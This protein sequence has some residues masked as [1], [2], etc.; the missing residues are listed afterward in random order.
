M[1]NRVRQK[2]C[3]GVMAKDDFLN[4]VSRRVENSAMRFDSVPEALECWARTQADCVA[5]R[6]LAD[7]EGD[8]VSL[9]YAELWHRAQG[10]AGYLVANGYRDQRV[11]LLMPSCLEYVVAFVACLL[12][13]TVA[14]PLYPPR[15]NW[16]DKRLADISNDAQACAALTLTAFA[17]QLMER[18]RAAGA[19]SMDTLVTVDR[20]AFEGDGGALAV[21]LPP[22]H[23]FV[24]AYLQYTSGSTGSPKGVMVRQSDIAWNVQSKAID[25][26]AQEVAV[27][28]LPL[29]HDMGLVQGIVMPLVRGGTAVFMPPTAF[30]QDPLRWLRAVDR[31]K[32]VFSGAPN[33]GYQSC[34]DAVP[35]DT[36]LALDLSSWR[37]AL[38]AAEPISSETV[39]QFHR[40]F[41]PYGLSRDAL[42]G[43]FGMAEATLYVT[44]GSGPGGAPV[45]HLDRH[46][47]SM[48]QIR[49]R[50]PESESV[51]ALVSSG[52]VSTDPLVRIVDT[53]IG[54]ALEDCQ[55]GEIWVSGS[56]V[57][58]G[59]WHNEP[60]T[61]ESFGHVLAS[62]PGESFLRT[63]DLGFT[64]QGHLYVT[65]RLK[66]LIIV[67]GANHYPQDI[68][69]D[70]EKAHP[71]F[72]TGRFSAAFTLDDRGSTAL[73]VVQEVKRTQRRRVD[74]DEIGPMVA[75]LIASQHGIELDQ[76]VLVEPGGVP[77]TSSGKVQRKAC[78]ALLL[79]G[80]L[81][82]IAVWTRSRS[83]PTVRP[84]PAESIAASRVIEN[85]LIGEVAAFTGLPASHIDVAMSFHALGLDS[86]KLVQLSARVGSAFG[87]RLPPSVIFDHP[88]ITALANHLSGVAR[89]PESAADVSRADPVAIIGLA[90]RVPGARDV[91]EFWQLVSS[92]RTAVGAVSNA[93]RHLT[94]FAA[95]AGSP[96]AYLGELSG[97]DVFDARLFGLAAR[98]VSSMDPQQRLALEVAWHALEN[99]GVAAD[100]LAGSATG[101][102]V[103][104]S[105]NDYFRLQQ[106]TGHDEYAATG[107]ALSI[108]ANR[109]SY[110]LGLQGPS[111]AI[112][113]ACSSSLVAVHQACQALASDDC[114]L[115]IAGG[116]NLVLSADHGDILAQARMLSADGHCHTFDQSAN[117]YVRGEGCGFVVL[118][119][120]HAAQRDGDRVLAVIRGSA[121]NQDGR[122][123]GLTAPN[124]TAQRQLIRTALKRA[125]IG[126]GSIGLVETHGTGTPL[127]DP[128]EVAALREVL[129]DAPN[130]RPCFLGAVKTNIGHLESAAGI[131]GLIKATMALTHRVIPPN[132]GFSRLNPH[133]DL[134][135]SRLSIPTR[136]QDWTVPEHERRC[137]GVSAF[138]FG[139]TNAHVILEEGPPVLLPTASGEAPSD[140]AWTLGLSAASEESLMRL[141]TEMARRLHR[142]DPGGARRLCV[143]MARHRAQLPERLAIAA[144]DAAALTQ[145]LQDWVAGRPARHAR[146]LRGRASGTHRGIVFLFTGQGSQYPGMGCGLV[147]SDPLFRAHIDACDAVL[148]PFLNAP[149]LEILE[150]RGGNYLSDTRYAQPALVALETGLVRLWADRGIVPTW[151]LG[152][153]VGEFA[154]A[155]A[156]GVMELHDALTL[157]ATRGRLMASAPGQGAMLSV[158]ASSEAVL[159]VLGAQGGRLDIASFNAV[160]QVVLSGE[161]E[162]IR[163]AHACL[164]QGGISCRQLTVSHAFHSRLMEPIVPTFR[165][166]MSA[167]RLAQPRCGFVPSGDG[168]GDPT[169]ATYWVDQLRAPVR[170]QQGVERLVAEG[171]TT[172]LEL[173]PST[174]LVDLTRCTAV[175]ADGVTTLKQGTDDALAFG[176]ARAVLF[177]L[178]AR[179]RMAGASALPGGQDMLPLYPMDPQRFWLEPHARADRGALWAQG[180]AVADAGVSSTCPPPDPS[181]LA[182]LDPG[183]ALAAL[184]RELGRLAAEV[185]RQPIPG[186]GEGLAATKLSLL[187]LDSLMAMDLRHRVR[188][189]I[190]V[191][192]P[193]HLL[194]SGSSLGDVS[195]LI[196]EQVLLRAVQHE[197]TA[198]DTSDTQ[199]VFVL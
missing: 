7:G 29:F 122:S 73:V 94:R 102:Y 155:V 31:F 52:L 138:G 98:E 161:E 132:H 65:G 66:D 165:T 75:R 21:R 97:V 143:A 166:A 10:L 36:D 18:L 19:R 30:V 148:R 177:A 33:F 183:D 107:S 4:L 137:A 105:S 136:A 78:R 54:R 157:V 91:H 162:S 80:R 74:V 197:P 154:A 106:S 171:A 146:I 47:L 24:V 140:G 49:I 61:A 6:F 121:V 123:N 113:T 134:E 53:G 100:R 81:P 174:T 116:V 135:G 57:C 77:N 90:C 120:L 167:V 43:A 111:M 86:A 139:G 163:T 178:G 35:A 149:L 13:G 37:T 76:L 34:V 141:A 38:N 26:N 194:I 96:Q 170:F 119:R 158:A 41:G 60:A 17:G 108:A 195:R 22:I 58:P 8:A 32:A 69:R 129:D 190:G 88:T 112:D 114:S 133:I 83:R 110:C 92:G 45:L 175:G 51:V 5:L 82:Q 182:K 153:S 159:R 118:K 20:G 192:L 156:A 1:A 176:E 150:D 93:R 50:T 28:W 172:F 2:G 198:S 124:G 145:A 152:H 64:H 3:V 168:R 193:A 95:V 11:L 186:Q 44:A 189:W 101:V 164:R 169:A 27:S 48:N 188:Q 84:E 16:H 89:L 191:D 12:A 127:G 67:R 185:L 72:R 131:I 130:E 59:Y 181:S 109:I 56:T 25:L 68:E 23:P 125:G 128:I 85:W 40:T 46:A 160:E 179:V 104:I 14:V 180:P 79:E 115:A 187:G 126:P 62:D 42:V 173:G 196:Y 39:Q 199:E 144:C 15:N 103:G 99:A 87:V 63:G 55:I 117:G 147:R 71:S 9:T 70:V 142:L 184:I 151:V